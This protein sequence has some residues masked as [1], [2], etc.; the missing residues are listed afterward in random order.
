MITCGLRIFVGMGRT[1]TRLQWIRAVVPKSD[2]VEAAA[3][4]V[5]AETEIGTEIESVAGVATVE[6]AI[7]SEEREGRHAVSLECEKAA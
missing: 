4:T 7:E 2:V 5:E 3:A 6:V 1:G